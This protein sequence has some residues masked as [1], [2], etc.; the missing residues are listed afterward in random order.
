MVSEN[1]DGC[2]A[3][4]GK[5]A[6]ERRQ[7][8]EDPGVVTDEVAS[9]NDDIGLQICDPP[10]RRQHIVIV[11][12]GSD[13]NVA[14]LN[15]GAARERSGQTANGQR[16]AHD[17]QPVRFDAARVQADACDGRHGHACGKKFAAADHGV[18][19]TLRTRLGN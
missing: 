19:L 2:H 16:T 15:Q 14:D 10:K 3:P 11:D 12:A 13:V 9:K 4:P 6:V 7:L 1:R 5:V 17:L 18:R 8:F